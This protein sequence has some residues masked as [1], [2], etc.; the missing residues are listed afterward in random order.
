MIYGSPCPVFKKESLFMKVKIDGNWIFIVLILA[1]IG[2]SVSDGRMGAVKKGQTDQLSI[3]SG[4]S[5]GTYYYI[6]AGQ[7]K[8]LTEY[9][10]GINVVTQSTSG[11]PV[12]NMTLVEQDPAN[13]GIVTID[14]I[15]YAGQGD[16]KRG[17]EEPLKNLRALIVG[18]KAYLYGLTVS[19]TGIGRY[20]DMVGKT[21]SVP[22][23]G[24]TTYYMAMA[25]A[26]AYGCNADNTNLIPMTPGEQAEALKDGTIDAA[27]M[28]GGI[29][30]ATVTD[31][32]YSND[33]VYLSI[34]DGT[35]E[36]LDQEYPFWSPVTI[37]KGTY[38]KQKEDMNCLT[39]DTLLAC[40]AELDENTAYQ[41]T[42]ILNEHVDELAA[43]HS[44]GLEWSLE[45]TE[46]YLDSDMFTFHDGA[47]KY[48]TEVLGDR[49][50]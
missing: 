40:N 34:D 43:I 18:H 13:L 6:A 5:G 26:E 37:K 7:A 35:I 49:G 30:Q 48:Y 33:V 31:L 32:D 20:E 2:I 27:F 41:I 15:Y 46:Q 25:V 36:K 23:I 3:M 8:I 21:I 29:P 11:S 19:G 42:K 47:L 22:P 24:S 1:L 28:A 50:R 4:N 45:T 9:L 44:S 12:E 39:V 14:G 10:D 38:T 17:F 16:V